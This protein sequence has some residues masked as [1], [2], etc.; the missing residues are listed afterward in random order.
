MF[1]QALN[2]FLFNTVDCSSVVKHTGY[3]FSQPRFVTLEVTNRCNLVCTFCLRHSF[4]WKRPDIVFGEMPIETVRLVL[5][6]VGKATEFIGLNGFGEPLCHSDFLR[7]VKEAHLRAPQAGLGFHTNGILLN[8]EKTLPQLIEN[9]I[10]NISVSLD[11]VDEQTYRSVHNNSNHFLK[12]TKNIAGC[13]KLIET[14]RSNLNLSLTYTIVPGNENRLSE[15]VKLCS[16]LG[17]RTVGPI[18]VVN[19]LWAA[20]SFTADA[21]FGKRVSTSLLQ[22]Q[23]ESEKLGLK[24]LKPDYHSIR[25]G[26][27]GVDHIKSHACSWPVA[28]AP[29]ISWQGDVL[30]CC[31]M[32]FSQETSLGNIHNTP[33]RKIWNGMPLRTLRRNLAK[34]SLPIGCNACKMMGAETRILPERIDITGTQKLKGATASCCK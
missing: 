24:F 13:S 22:A 2:R 17:V 12:I 31:W 20:K 27:M 7:V 4:R 33:L 14:E 34:G 11:A 32:P 6:Q 30:V 25:P 10:T 8:P 26:S 18:H 16:D 5:K 28:Y 3:F 19:E 23:E 29:L 9:G 15:F 21:G 1:Y